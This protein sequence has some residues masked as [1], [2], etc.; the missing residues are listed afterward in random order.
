MRGRFN[1]IYSR[2]HDI[3]G[4]LMFPKDEDWLNDDLK[5]ARDKVGLLKT[6]PNTVLDV[7][8]GEGAFIGV[9]K[10]KFPGCN[11]YGID[12]SDVGIENAKKRFPNGNYLVADATKIPFDNEYFDL[13]VSEGLLHIIEEE[14]KIKILKEIHRVLKTD[15]IFICIVGHKK[16]N[17]PNSLLFEEVD[18][19][20]QMFKKI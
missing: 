18:W 2:P 15:G 12:I 10:D 4:D 8:C 14:N 11:A 1:S 13:V 16:E 6:K 5:R 9:L 7:G 3:T 19:D 17:S 20:N